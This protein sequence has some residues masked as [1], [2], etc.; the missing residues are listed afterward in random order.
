MDKKGNRIIGVCN[1]QPML[2]EDYKIGVPENGI[3]A[4]V[5]NTDDERFGGTGITNGQNIDSSG[6]EMHEMDQSIS[7]TLPPMSVMYFKCI[8]KKPPRPKK[9]RWVRMRKAPEERAPKASPERTKPL[10][11]AKFAAGINSLIILFY[12]K[13]CADIQ[14]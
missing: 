4:E 7:I 13:F 5:F 11:K 9:K 8:K 14:R 2:R 12:Y 6:E 1:F 3:Y 10:N